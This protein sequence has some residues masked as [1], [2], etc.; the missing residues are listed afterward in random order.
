MDADLRGSSAD[1]TPVSSKARPFAYKCMLIV[2]R[3]R[4]IKM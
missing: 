2:L 3:S 1:D 4:I